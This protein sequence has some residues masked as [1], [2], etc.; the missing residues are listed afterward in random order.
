MAKVALFVLPRLGDSDAAI[1]SV[2]VSLA[3]VSYVI[4]DHYLG[5]SGVVSVVMA[6]LAVAAN[7]PTKLHPRQWSGLVRLWHQLEFWSNSLIFILASMAAARVLPHCRR[8]RASI[9]G[10]WSG[11]RPA[12]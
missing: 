8:S 9:G 7:G 3:Y 5:V 6:A 12:R 1:A 2:T 11:L 10:D 4:G